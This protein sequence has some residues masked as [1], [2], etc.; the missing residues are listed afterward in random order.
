MNG[1]KEVK[2]GIFIFST[3]FAEAALNRERGEQI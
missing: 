2:S 1:K 3:E